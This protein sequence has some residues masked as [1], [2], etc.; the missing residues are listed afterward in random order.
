[1]TKRSLLSLGPW[2]M[3][4]LA[5]VGCGDTENGGG[6]DP[7]KG[8]SCACDI[9]NAA[10]C[11]GG[12]VCRP[13]GDKNVCEPEGTAG[14][15]PSC[16]DPNGLDVYAAEADGALSVSWKV[17]GN[18][19]A[20]GGFEVRYG[21]ASGTHDQ[22]LKVGSEARRA[23]IT[24]LDNDKIYYVVVAP[25]AAGGMSSFV[26]CQVAGIPHELAFGLDVVV[27]EVTEGNQ[28]D[29]DLAANIDGSRLYLAWENG[30]A[31]GLAIS[32]DFGDTWAEAKPVSASGTN[33]A[34]VV[35]DAVV[36]KD[37]KVLKPEMLHVTWEEGGKILFSTFDPAEGS[38][39]A[40]LTVGSGT[41]PDI[42][43]GLDRV[44]VAYVENNAI[45]H[46]SALDGAAA[47]EVPIAISG[48]LT[49]T[50]A[51]SVTVHPTSGDV[52]VAWDA[53]EGAGDSNVYSATSKDAGMTFDTPV[54]IDDDKQGQNQT[55]VSVTSDPQ[56]GELFATW[57]D[58]RGGANVF[59]ST[60]KDGGATW[61]TNIDVGAGLGGDQFHPRAVVDVAGNV[62]VAFQDTTNGQRV[63]F[64]RFNEDG[65]FD[66][67]LAPS[68]VAGAGG[69]VGDFPTV[70]TDVF[71]T[72]YVAWE[73]NR[74]GPDLEVV[75]GRA[76]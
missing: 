29:P 49:K 45:Q 73:E 27:N 61:A 5:A 67:P 70:A 7:T 28:G 13:S 6:C 55:N 76:D 3:A 24:P 34:I 17:N 23:T 31:V 20:A 44:H 69:V 65:T 30:G 21:T 71:G 14:R 9:A 43:L 62:Y 10:S 48:G 32:K 19:D 75:F 64:S 56:T 52:I 12:Y 60:S 2:M 35:H 41:S 63:V 54:R 25:L 47:F 18:L 40:P 1:M 74:N 33:P 42:A 50:Q 58:R 72:V 39:S 68:T 53:L 46:A 16:Q 57:E 37:G 22:T 59:F 26:S 38:Y 51:P 4:V 8:D 66:P 36:D 15:I 11:P